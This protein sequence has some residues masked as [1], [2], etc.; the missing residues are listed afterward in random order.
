M[1]PRDRRLVCRRIRLGREEEV[2]RTART[3]LAQQRDVGGNAALALARAPEGKTSYLSARLVELDRRSAELSRA[4]VEASTSKTYRYLK[5]DYDLFCCEHNLDWAAPESV[6]FYVTERVDASEPKATIRGRV[7]AIRRCALLEGVADPTADPYVQATIRGALKKLGGEPRRVEAATFPRIGELIDAIENAFVENVR[8]GKSRGR[9]ANFIRT[10]DRALVL[11]GFALGRRGSELARVDV[12][13]IERRSD[14]II[15][16][17]PWTKTNK[18][19]EPEFVGIPAFHEHPLCPVRALDVWLHLAKI[20]SGPVFVTLSPVRGRGGQRMRG[21]D[22]SRR[23]AVVAAN[24]N[25]PGLWRSHS[26]RRGVVTSAEVLNVSRSR[27]RQLTGWRSERMFE[28]YA[29][30]DIKPSTSPLNDIY[31]K[32]S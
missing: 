20:K 15:V 4:T 10:R 26:L 28:V 1:E 2:A 12:E 31:G 30:H 23:L 25:L 19:G 13:H 6:R 21:E 27:T 16:K 18:T 5:V 29:S 17:I 3:G 8:A 9:E 11:L 14:G 32:P 24:A 22:I 7:A